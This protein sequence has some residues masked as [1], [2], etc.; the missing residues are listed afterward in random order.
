MFSALQI[1][2]NGKIAIF[3]LSGF[4]RIFRWFWLFGPFFLL[5]ERTPA[6]V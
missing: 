1:F 5:I 4:E 2:H 6:D 3:E